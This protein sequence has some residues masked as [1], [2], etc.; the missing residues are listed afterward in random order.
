MTFTELKSQ[1][2]S[3]TPAEKAE[4]IQLLSQSL[5]NTWQGINKTPGV[6]GGDACIRQTRIP[7]WLLVSYQRSGLSEAKILDNYPTLSAVDLANAWSYAQVYANEIEA[8]IAKHNEA[9]NIVPLRTIN[10]W[11]VNQSVYTLLV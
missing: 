10:C 11:C 3:L 5:A 2:L 8:A 1:L 9:K 4:V 6:M 7:V